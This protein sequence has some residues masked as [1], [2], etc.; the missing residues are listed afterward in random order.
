M[1]RM[2]LNNISS[3]VGEYGA[4]PSAAMNLH[5]LL[6]DHETTSLISLASRFRKH[7]YRGDCLICIYTDMYFL[8]YCFRNF[9]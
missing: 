1:V 2:E 5:V 6:V 9:C 3:Q 8:T 7:F 4:L